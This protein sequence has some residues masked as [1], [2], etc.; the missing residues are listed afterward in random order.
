MAASVGVKTPSVMPTRIIAGVMR[1][2]KA[3]AVAITIS[4]RVARL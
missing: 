3:I 4:V 1:A 2:Q